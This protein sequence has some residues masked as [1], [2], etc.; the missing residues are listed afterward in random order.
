MN[1]TKNSS[2]PNFVVDRIED[3]MIVKHYYYIR[4]ENFFNWF[5]EFSH[6]I[7]LHEGGELFCS[8]WMTKETAKRINRRFPDTCI[9]ITNPYS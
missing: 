6:Q 9:L 5:H 2:H 8:G 4:R 1:D 3:E 7:T